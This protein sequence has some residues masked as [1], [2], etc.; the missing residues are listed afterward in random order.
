[1]KL[2][3]DTGSA[4]Q[5]NPALS[6]LSNGTI[7]VSWYDRRN[8]PNNCLTDVY[9]TVSTNSGANFSANAK[10]TLASSDYDG[11]PNGPGDYSGIAPQPSSL[12]TSFPFWA[13]HLGSDIS[14]ETGTAGAFEIYT[15]PVSH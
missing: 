7:Y 6:V 12:T 10:V 2:N 8:D 1:M 11:N 13:S 4:D 3:D 15:A 9:S 5:Y 14:Q